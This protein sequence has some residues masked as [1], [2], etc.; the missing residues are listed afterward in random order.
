[1]NNH[2]ISDSEFRKYKINECLLKM[3]YSEHREALRKI[4]VYL[5]IALNTFHN[6]RNILLNAKQDIPHEIVAK[7]EML[8]EL[9]P[10][11]LLNKKLKKLTLQELL[12]IE[13]VKAIAKKK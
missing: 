12:K 3:T 2:S 1:M 7:L 13:N 10:G 11:E 4:P 5:G 8:F 6:Y 9:R